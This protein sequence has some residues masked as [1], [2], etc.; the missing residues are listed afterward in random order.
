[1][2]YFPVPYNTTQQRDIHFICSF[3]EIAALGSDVVALLLQFCHKQEAE[4]KL[5]LRVQEESVIRSALFIVIEDFDFD[6]TGHAQFEFYEGF[7]TL[8]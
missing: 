5:L 2:R 1:M 8:F 7:T 4:A 6:C 3:R